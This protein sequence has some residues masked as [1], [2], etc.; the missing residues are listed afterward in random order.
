MTATTPDLERRHRPARPGWL[1]LSLLASALLLGWAALVPIGHQP[2]W[3]HWI[4]AVLAVAVFLGSWHGQHVSTAA[5]RWAPMAWR[6]RRREVRSDPPPAAMVNDAVQARIIIHLRPHPHALL[7]PEDPVDLLPWEFLTSWLHRYGIRADSLT[8]CSMTRTPAPSSLRSDAA[9]LVSARTPAH[10]D[11]W[12]VYTLRAESNLGALAARRTTITAVED[13]EADGGGDDQSVLRRR[14]GLADVTGRRLIAELRE[15]GWLA[16]LCDDPDKLP[17]FVPRGSGNIRRECWTGTEYSDGFRAV[18]AVQPQALAEVLH[19]LPG[20]STKATWTSVTIRA[21]S[22]RPATVSA[23]VAMLTAAR[24]ALEPLP[25]L[26]GLHGLHRRAAA[27][28]SVAG[29]DPQSGLE[30]LPETE[31]EAS[32]LL[33][34]PWATAGMGVPIGFN[35]SRQPVYV[36]LASPEPV[37]IT[38]TGAGDFHLGVVARLALAG[39]PIAV[40]TRDPKFWTKLANSAAPQQVQL[41]PAAVATG[42]IIVSD[43]G[44]DTPVGPVMVN[45]RRPQAAEAPATKIVI[46]Q[47]PRRADLFTIT[48]PH[49]RQWLST[50]L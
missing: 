13:S 3:W 12:L 50:H 39:L 17:S 7:T 15:R 38:V 40:Y 29:L 19:A 47:D 49:G 5:A 1:R 31:L 26:V 35:R 22:P 4:L 20:L 21:D 16:T 45:L 27:A 9:A 25:G 34:L 43:R 30:V 8:V 36:G 48:T 32:G 46:S 11:T 37:R 24:P 28:L 2:R 10:R 18:Y 14:D 23:C 42:S 41:N 6:N 44:V 33:E